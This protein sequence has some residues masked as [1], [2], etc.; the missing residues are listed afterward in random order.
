MFGL[1]TG[2]GI[3]I[4]KEMEQREIRRQL[5]FSPP[6]TDFDPVLQRIYV[7]SC[8]NPGPSEKQSSHRI[9]H[10]KIR[11]NPC[12]GKQRGGWGNLS[13]HDAD[14]TLGRKEGENSSWKLKD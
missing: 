1:E 12:E 5:L 2:I 13:D 6:P 10:A 14:L 8:V 7:I 9:S 4:E 3:D 11:G